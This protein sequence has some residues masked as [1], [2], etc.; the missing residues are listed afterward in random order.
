MK[1]YFAGI[2]KVKSFHYIHNTITHFSSIKT[3]LG[4]IIGLDKYLNVRKTTSKEG[5]AEENNTTGDESRHRF[6]EYAFF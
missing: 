1:R 6:I 3:R 5:F 2:N 4:I